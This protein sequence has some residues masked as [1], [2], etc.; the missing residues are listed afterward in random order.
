MKLC[1]IK[2]RKNKYVKYY[3]KLKINY[4]FSQ[5]FKTYFYYNYLLTII[6]FRVPLI[7]TNQYF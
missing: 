4:I 5:Y 3:R 6:K 2:H 7:L 1:N